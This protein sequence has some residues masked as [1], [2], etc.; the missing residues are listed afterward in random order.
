[1][2]SVM[3]TYEWLLSHY[4][5]AQLLYATIK[6]DAV[7]DVVAALNNTGCTTIEEAYHCLVKDTR[8]NP[9]VS[10]AKRMVIDLIYKEARLEGIGV[11]FPQTCQLYEGANV[12][13]LSVDDVLKI[14]NLKHAWQFI[15]DTL[16]EKVTLPYVSQVNFYVQA[17]LSRDCGQLRNMPVRIGGTDWAPTMPNRAEAMY[18]IENINDPLELCAY[19]MRSQLFSDGNKRTAQLVANQ[20]LISRNI[21]VLAIPVDQLE[22]FRTLLI[23]YYETANSHSI[24]QFMRKCIIKP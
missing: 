11:T 19:L 13:H 6:S 15:F 14:N 21:G 3:D 17:G 12:A 24:V 9:Y 7:Q 4:S 2:I 22:E 8:S 20:L 5:E 18:N 10:L 16:N 23:A 1:M